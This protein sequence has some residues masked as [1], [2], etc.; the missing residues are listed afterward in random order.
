MGCSFLLCP[1]RLGLVV[2]ERD[3]SPSSS[4]HRESFGEVFRGALNILFKN[5]IVPFLCIRLLC[6]GVFF[7]V[8]RRRWL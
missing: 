4:V 8:A 5:G 3:V 7:S 6:V 2:P 1:S